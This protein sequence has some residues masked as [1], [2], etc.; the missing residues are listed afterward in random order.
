MVRP[1]VDPV[2]LRHHGGFCKVAA[3]RRR[4][5]RLPIALRLRQEAGKTGL[6]VIGPLRDPDNIF[7]P[8]DWLLGPFELTFHSFFGAAATDI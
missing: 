4:R 5:R 1:N 3:T 7:G 2:Y 6:K 8:R